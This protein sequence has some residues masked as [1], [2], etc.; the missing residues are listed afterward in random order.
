MDDTSGP[1]AALFGLLFAL[2][3]IAI[4]VLPASI[5]FRR[6]VTNKW[7]LLWLTLAL[8][9]TLIGWVVCLIWAVSGAT[10]AQDDFYRDRGRRDHQT[11]GPNPWEQE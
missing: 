10:Q 8:G 5:G 1:I 6:G 9:W 2:G 3:L 11:R 4:Y 7:L